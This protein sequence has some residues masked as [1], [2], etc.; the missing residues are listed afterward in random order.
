M[1]RIRCPG[2]TTR[3]M[4]A[5]SG[6]SVSSSAFRRRGRSSPGSSSA[7][8][9]G[10]GLVVVSGPSLGGGEVNEVLQTA[11]GQ[12]KKSVFLA[13]PTMTNRVT[14]Q[15]AA[16]MDALRQAADDHE[17]GFEFKFSMEYGKSPVEYARN[18][19][20]GS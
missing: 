3:R 16:F 4:P 15:I 19:L 17:S 9:G 18:V 1:S 6:A 20:C 14:I 11:G 10:R 8:R 12:R 5:W 2:L 13:I 7:S